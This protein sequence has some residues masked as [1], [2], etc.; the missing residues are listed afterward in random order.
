LALDWESADIIYEQ[1]KRDGEHGVEEK[2]GRARV[3]L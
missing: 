3:E 2:E 1:N